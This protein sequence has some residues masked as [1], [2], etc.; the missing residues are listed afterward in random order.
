MIEA[1]LSLLCV[2]EPVYC[3][4][5]SEFFLLH[6]AGL[7]STCEKPDETC[8]RRDREEFKV[9]AGFCILVEQSPL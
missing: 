6:S 8:H 5:P 3:S 4:I 1:D 7:L 2:L 9:V